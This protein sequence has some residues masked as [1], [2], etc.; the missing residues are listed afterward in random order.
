VP[1]VVGSGLDCVGSKLQVFILSQFQ[2]LPGGT[3][4][5]HENPQQNCQ[6]LDKD[7]SWAP[8][9]ISLECYSFSNLL[10]V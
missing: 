8:P 7:L 2:H 10:H 6:C 5:I 1:H 3:E 4:E 9:H